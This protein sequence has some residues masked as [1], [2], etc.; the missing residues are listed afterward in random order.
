M[1]KNIPWFI[2]L[3]IIVSFLL[4]YFPRRRG[5][6]GFIFENMEYIYAVIISGILVLIVGLFCLVNLEEK[7]KK[8]IKELEINKYL[9]EQ[10]NQSSKR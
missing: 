7:Y 10:E 9:L 3:G 1:R 4:P 6:D 5:R 8:K 2:V